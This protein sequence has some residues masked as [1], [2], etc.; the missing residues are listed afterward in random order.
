MRFMYNTVYKC[1]RVTVPETKTKVMH[2]PKN[3]THNKQ[4]EIVTR[5]E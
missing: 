4:K 3:M 2:D 5:H 1:K